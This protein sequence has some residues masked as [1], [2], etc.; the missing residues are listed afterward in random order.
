METRQ[1]QAIVAQRHPWFCDIS[2]YEF[3]ECAIL[4]LASPRT[5]NQCCRYI[6]TISYEPLIAC[7][8]RCAVLIRSLVCAVGVSGS[9]RAINVGVNTAPIQWGMDE[10]YVLSI[11]LF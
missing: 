10:R 8:N 9:S 6:F 11:Q 4:S 3:V 7:D 2:K 1:D 5:M